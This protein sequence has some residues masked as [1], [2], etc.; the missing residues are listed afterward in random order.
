MVSLRIIPT[1]AVYVC[2]ED[3]RGRPLV[4]KQTLVAGDATRTFR[5]RRFRVTFGTAN[6]RMRVNGRRYPVASSQAAVGYELRPG[7]R[8]RRLALGNLPTCS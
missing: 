6:A 5:S 4:D 1:G 8:P 7:R 2:L 3:A